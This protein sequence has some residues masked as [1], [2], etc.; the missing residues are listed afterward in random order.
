MPRKS[1]FTDE[2]IIRALREV[3]AGAK[4]ADVARRLGVTV[5]F[6]PRQDTCPLENR[7]VRVE[8]HLTQPA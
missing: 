8:R 7:V 6:P 1:K 2:Q 5:V 4:P 3:D